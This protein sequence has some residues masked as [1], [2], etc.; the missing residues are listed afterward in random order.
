ML[1]LSL[2]LA[3]VVVLV[4]LIAVLCQ[5]C[6]SPLMWVMHVCCDTVGGLLKALFWC[7]EGAF[8]AATGNE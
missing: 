1:T 6:N 2:I 3:A 4:V 8:K 5:M 7:L